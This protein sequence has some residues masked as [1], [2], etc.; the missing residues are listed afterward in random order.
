MRF[1]FRL[2]CDVGIVPIEEDVKPAT[3]NIAARPNTISDNNPSILHPPFILLCSKE[4][5]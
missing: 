2:A 4:S 1:R 5:N 3:I